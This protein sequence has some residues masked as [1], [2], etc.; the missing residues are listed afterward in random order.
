[1]HQLNRNSVPAPACITPHNPARLYGSLRKPQYAEIRGSLL[2]MQQNRCAYCERRTGT[3][4]KD[5]HIEHFRRQVDFPGRTT[6]WTNL[7]WSCN[8]I[9][10]CGRHKDTCDVNGSTG[11]CR[12]FNPNDIIDPCADDPHHFMHFISDGSIQPRDNLSAAEQLRF[13]ETLRVF[14]LA[15]AG[16][17]VDSRRDAVKPYIDALNDLKDFGP[18]IV[19][20]YINRKFPQING[21]PFETAIRHFLQSNQP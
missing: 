16:L 15:D 20:A 4:E 7:F 6:D 11:K 14:Q 10:F 21:V 3:G 17:L 9:N 5:G 13:S 18:E 12:P 19:Q 2:T 1:M 8:D